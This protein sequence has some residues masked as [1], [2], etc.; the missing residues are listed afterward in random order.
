MGWIGL[1]LAGLG[2]SWLAWARAGWLG[3][4]LGLAWAFARAGYLPANFFFTKPKKS[5]KYKT[6]PRYQTDAQPGA[7][8]NNII[9]RNEKI[10]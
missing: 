10:S 8:L 9:L 5:I 3:L 2:S 1:E 6:A 4:G 7:L